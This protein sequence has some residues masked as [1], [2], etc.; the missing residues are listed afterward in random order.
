M[1]SFAE[2]YDA[3][4]KASPTLSFAEEYDKAN[5]PPGVWSDIKNTLATGFQ[6][7]A[8]DAREIARRAF[9]E[10]FVGAVDT[11]DEWM[12]GKPSEEL[13]K[14]NIEKAQ[15]A[16]TPEMQDAMQKTWW[17]DETN[18]LGDAW[19]DPRAYL[20]NVMQSLPGTA[21]TM[22]PAI[23]IARG[24]YVAERAALVAGGMAEAEAA[25]LAA[26]KAATAAQLAGGLTEGLQ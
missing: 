1:A 6:G 11:V 4:Q 2:E 22:L 16:L 15:Q 21:V 19:K 3:A 13:I 5:P 12:H 26:A 14:G 10:K 7:L 17:N 20:G 23:G 18:S 8:L 9:G 24:L 25:T